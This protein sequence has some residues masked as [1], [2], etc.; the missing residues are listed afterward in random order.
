MMKLE[1]LRRGF[2]FEKWWLAICEFR[3]LVIKV[4]ALEVNSNNIVD[5]WQA[6]LRMF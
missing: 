1:F 3:E 6:K 5:V 4:W 2:K